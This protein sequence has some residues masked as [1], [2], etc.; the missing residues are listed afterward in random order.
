MR[1]QLQPGIFFNGRTEW[2]NDKKAANALF[3]GSPGNTYALTAN[4]DWQLNA[5]LNVITEVKYDIYRGNGLPLFANKTE[6][7]QL[8][9]LVNFIIKF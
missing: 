8:L 5:Y 3:A 2:V 6:N 4:I 9:G 7:N 1:Y